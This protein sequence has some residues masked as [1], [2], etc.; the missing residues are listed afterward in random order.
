MTIQAISNVSFKGREE[1]LNVAKKPVVDT[2]YQYVGSGTIFPQVERKADEAT[3]RA[4]ELVKSIIHTP[5]NHRSPY[6]SP[7]LNKA[8]FESATKSY[9]QSHANLKISG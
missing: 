7:D 9:K 6:Q 1:C 2:F 5:Y 4:V 3:Q 8:Y